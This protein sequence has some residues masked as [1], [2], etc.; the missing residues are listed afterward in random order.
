MD[1]VAISHRLWQ[2]AEPREKIGDYK[3]QAQGYHDKPGISQRNKRTTCP[4]ET[5]FA[6]Y[7]VFLLKGEEIK[8]SFVLPKSYNIH[9]LNV[10]LRIIYR[11]C[12]L[13]VQTEPTCN[14]SR[15]QETL[16]I[17]FRKSL[18]QPPCLKLPTPYALWFDRILAGLWCG[19]STGCSNTKTLILLLCLISDVNRVFQQVFFFFF[20]RLSSLNFTL[21]AFEK[22][23]FWKYFIL[24]QL[25]QALNFQQS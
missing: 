3:E 15:L 24:K 18:E 13:C 23:K 6:S 1:L 16:K 22:K 8:C 25:F 20:L 2:S 11:F 19:R 10:T 7:S 12:V 9:T 4:M 17:S 5:S 14:W 21:P